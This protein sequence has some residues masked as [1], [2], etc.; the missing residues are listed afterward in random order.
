MKSSHF[1]VHGARL[2]F[3]AVIIC[4]FKCHLTSFISFIVLVAFSRCH[5]AF[6]IFCGYRAFFIGLSQISSFFSLVSVTFSFELHAG[7]CLK[8]NDFH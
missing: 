5:V 6:L 3:L 1:L 8:V 7:V 4:I 2:V